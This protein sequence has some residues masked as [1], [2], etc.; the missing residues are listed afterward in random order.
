MLLRIDDRK[1]EVAKYSVV[2]PRDVLD[3]RNAS[4]TGGMLR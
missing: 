2:P 1:I 3:V 4:V